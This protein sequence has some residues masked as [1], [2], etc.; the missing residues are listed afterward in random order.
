MEFPSFLCLQ[1][2][3]TPLRGPFIHCAEAIISLLFFR[4]NFCM[5]RCRLGVSWVRGEFGVFLCHHLG[6][7]LSTYD[8]YNYRH[9]NTHFDL[10]I[11]K[12][13]P[14]KDWAKNNEKGQNKLFLVLLSL[15]EGNQ[16]RK[17]FYLQK[18]VLDFKRNFSF[19]LLLKQ[20]I[21]LTLCFYL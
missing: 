15:G 21:V 6:H 11:N 8:S 13:G 18:Q 17:L 9:T 12:N 14:K 20:N 2:F 3:Y 7:L 19:S 10:F 16:S 1:L 4:K 5:C